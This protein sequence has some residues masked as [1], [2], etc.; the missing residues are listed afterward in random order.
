[1][2]RIVAIKV[3]TGVAREVSIDAIFGYEPPRRLKLCAILKSCW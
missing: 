1:M 2:E 3:S